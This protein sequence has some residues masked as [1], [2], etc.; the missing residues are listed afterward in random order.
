MADVNKQT[1][2]HTLYT[3]NK[4]LRSVND[5]LLAYMTNV[6]NSLQHQAE[7]I[8]KLQTGGEG[9]PITAVHVT[10]QFGPSDPSI[11][12]TQYHHPLI[13]DTDDFNCIG[14]KALRAG[15]AEAP[16]RKFVMSAPVGPAVPSMQFNQ[17]AGTNQSTDV[18]VEIGSL[19]L[20]K[21][22][23]L[24]MTTKDYWPGCGVPLAQSSICVLRK[25]FRRQTQHS[26]RLMMLLSSSRTPVWLL[27]ILSRASHLVLARSY[28]VRGLRRDP[29]L[30]VALV[31]LPQLQLI[32]LK[33]MAI[34]HNRSDLN[35]QRHSWI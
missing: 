4:R 23:A 9:V 20:F 19:S 21:E 30:A 35:L 31:N 11:Q 1:T 27:L 6:Q 2:D 24:V 28:P 15:E 13:P 14:T 29:A 12:L 34:Y 26:Q 16:E 18:A 7:V 32:C 33:S 10:P 8:K 25:V 17:H 22:S 3:E 5:D